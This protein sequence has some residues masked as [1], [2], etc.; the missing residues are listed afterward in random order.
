MDDY[1]VLPEISV[2]ESGEII[3]PTRLALTGKTVSPGLFDIMALLGKDVCLSRI[4]KAID[5]IKN[6]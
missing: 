4:D 5:W 6:R 3:H 1:L 2:R